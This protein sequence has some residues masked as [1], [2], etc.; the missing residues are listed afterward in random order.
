MARD[1]TTAA[2]GKTADH[3][4]Q[5]G[6]VC[7]ATM[8]ASEHAKIDARREEKG[9]RQIQPKFDATGGEDPVYDTI[10]LALSGGGIR[11]AAFSLGALQALESAGA[12][13]QVDYLSTVSGGGYTG[14]CW[15]GFSAHEDKEGL[16]FPSE[17]KADEPAP[18]R[19]IRDHSNYLIPRG[20]WDVLISSAIYLRGIAA[21]VLL[22]LPWLLLAAA[23]TIALYPTRQDLAKVSEAT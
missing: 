17:L 21:N 15:S 2:E 13:D 5:Q 6:T 3:A 14:V 11:S 16:P 20:L 22:I 18:L 12:L 4:E 10:G 23:I 19:H 1:N 7:F 8:H 9:R